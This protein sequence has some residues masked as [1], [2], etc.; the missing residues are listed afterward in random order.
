MRKW[1]RRAIIGT[2]SLVGGGFVLG[3]A[4]V[5]LAPS[6]HSIVPVL[7]ALMKPSGS[8]GASHST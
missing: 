2:G 6:R 7:A 4:G 1:T 5:V 3:V 8:S